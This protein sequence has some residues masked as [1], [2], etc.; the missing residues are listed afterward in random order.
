MVV[1]VVTHIVHNSKH[2]QSEQ[3]LAQIIATFENDRDRLA[4]GIGIGEY[5]PYGSLG[6]IHGLALVYDNATYRQPM[7][8]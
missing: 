6:R 8:E 5:D 1:V 2:L 3:I 4:Q 7:Y